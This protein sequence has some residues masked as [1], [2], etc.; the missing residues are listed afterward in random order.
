MIAAVRD[1]LIFTLHLQHVLLQSP[2]QDSVAL[3]NT[4]YFLGY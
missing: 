1:I 2:V 4:V 3:S